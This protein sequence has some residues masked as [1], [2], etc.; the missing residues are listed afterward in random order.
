MG[1]PPENCV[2]KTVHAQFAIEWIAAR[3]DPIVIVIRR[4]LL[5]VIGSWLQLGFVP[6]AIDTPFELRDHPVIKRDYLEP[7]GLDPPSR[8]APMMQQIAWHVG[9]LS[10]G[11]DRA[12][13]Q[14]P[15]WIVV[16]HEGL[17][18]SP[19]ERFRELFS[20]TGLTWTDAVDRELYR[21]DKPGTGVGPQRVARDRVD[22]W[23]VSLT[24]EQVVE[25]NRILQPFQT[26][27]GADS[28]AAAQA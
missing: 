16:D 3:Y 8:D 9:L 28:G 4:N 12:I 13:A 21:L 20:R 22:S 27:V 5:S 7:L 18:E 25:A 26:S 15:E 19:F 1:R 17:C 24:P 2:T 11:L 14:H 6:Y 10:L 23:K